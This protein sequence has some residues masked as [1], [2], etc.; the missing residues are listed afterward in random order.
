[1][2]NHSSEAK[3]YS[4][5]KHLLFAFTIVFDLSIFYI[6]FV[7][8]QSDA[9]RQ[10]A[11][12]IHANPFAANAIYLLCFGILMYVLHFPLSLFSGFIWEHKYK[13]SNQTF[14]Q[15][16]KDD[17][18]KNVLGFLLMLVLLEVVYV[19]LGKTGT[20]WWIWASCFWILVSVGLAK[21]TPNVIVP[22]FFKYATVE[23]KELKDQIF[24]IFD[25]CKVTL[26]DVYTINLS[27]KTKKANAFLCGLGKS[28]RVVLSDTLV[29][30]FTPSEIE[31]VVAHELGHYK[32][33]D[34]A[35]FL[36]IQSVF[37]FLSFFLA[38]Q[39]IRG[40]MKDY[41]YSSID[42]IALL[43]MFVFYLTLINLVVMPIINWFSRR[44]EV[45]ADRFSLDVTKK[46]EDFISL[47]EKLAKMNL[48]ELQ[49]NVWVERILY[50]HPS[51]HSR[52]LF[53]QT[54]QPKVSQ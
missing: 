27:A 52:I 39:A 19:F 51:I 37:T 54:Y 49:P 4:H 24:K 35:K 30:H 47:M 9:F 1:M 53:A 34:I 12:S 16:L 28:R 11:F 45:K 5:V 44:V 23:N 21:I 17:V 41:G 3:R 26:K 13:L 15:W 22:L 20:S 8:G 33:K 25:Q 43:P 10:K 38:D 31:V 48:A 18:K 50:D 7:S 42:N 2:M 14:A 36:V 29:E 40:V 46:P 32:H 6:F